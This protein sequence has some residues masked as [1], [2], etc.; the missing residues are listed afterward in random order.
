LGL[1]G[2]MAGFVRMSKNFVNLGRLY[3]SPPWGGPRN[4]VNL[5]NLYTTSSPKRPIGFAYFEDGSVFIKARAYAELD[6]F[7][8][9]MNLLQPFVRGPSP[10]LDQ[11]RQTNAERQRLIVIA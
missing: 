2:A 7:E 5:G 3:S 4:A 1:A 10:K 6:T 9:E 8:A 11:I